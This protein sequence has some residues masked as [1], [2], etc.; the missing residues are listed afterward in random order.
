MSETII[1]PLVLALLFILFASGAPIFLCLG[2]SGLVGILLIRG[3]I[4]LFQVTGSMYAQVDSFVLVAVPLFILMG[5]AVFITGIGGQ[6]Y[7]LASKWLYRLPGGL[8][9]ASVVACAI[10]GAMCGVSI[11]G[12]ATIGVMAIPE[13]VQR[14]YRRD[15]AVGAVTSAGALAMLIPPSVV[16]IIYGDVAGVS[17]GKLFI[18]GIVPGL[19][20]AMFMS[21][22]VIVRVLKNPSLAPRAVTRISWKEKLIPLKN[23]WAPLLLIAAVLG[24]IYTGVATPTESGAMGAVGSLVLAAVAYHTLNLKT[25]WKVVSETVRVTGAILIIMACAMVFSGYLSLVKIPET[26]CIAATSLP[27]PPVGTLAIVMVILII[28]GMFVDAASVIIVTTPILLP[29]VKAIGIDPLFYGILVVITLEMAVIT[30]PV[31]L[32]LY[33]LK[34]IAPETPMSDIFRGTMPYVGIEL[35]CLVLF[36]FLP[37]LALWLP[38]T[39]MK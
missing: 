36:M 21:T 13:M 37:Q 32:N 10:F 19:V 1:T 6:I 35:A 16:F 9:V 2:F 20:M 18:G 25:L 31:G 27:L 33:T 14:G 34:S 17:V 5:Q 29:V 15:F 22:Y 24:T 12:V 11:A 26:V 28:V 38:S 30:P 8:A 4:G 7:E 3:P 39:M 23:L